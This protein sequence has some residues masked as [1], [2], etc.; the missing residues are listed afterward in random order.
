MGPLLERA[1]SIDQPATHERRNAPVQYPPT[2]EVSRAIRRSAWV[3]QVANERS[4]A[5]C[6]GWVVQGPIRS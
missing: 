2:T 5:N 1:G 6:V 3:V 4:V